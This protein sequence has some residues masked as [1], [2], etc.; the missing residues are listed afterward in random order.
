MTTTCKYCGSEMIYIETTT[1]KQMPCEPSLIPVWRTKAGKKRAITENGETIACEYEPVPF[2]ERE[3]AY[4]PHWS[5]CN[6]KK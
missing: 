4:K 6:F 3:L 2:V 1:G 5:N